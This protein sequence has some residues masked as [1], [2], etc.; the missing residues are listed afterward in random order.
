MVG[1]VPQKQRYWQKMEN[2][3]VE[4]TAKTVQG[5]AGITLA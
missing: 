1:M 5:C 4:L 3:K 2:D